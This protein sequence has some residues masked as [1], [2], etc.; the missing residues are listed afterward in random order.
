MSWGAG[1]RNSGPRWPS[2]SEIQLS[3]QRSTHPPTP[4]S[5]C[6]PAAHLIPNPLWRHAYRCTRLIKGY[7][8]MGSLNLPT[9]WIPLETRCPPR[10]VRGVAERFYAHARGD[11]REI[12][13][14]CGRPRSSCTLRCARRRR[15]AA[16]VRATAGTMSAVRVTTHD[17]IEL[18]NNVSGSPND[19]EQARLQWRVCVGHWRMSTGSTR[20]CSGAAPCMKICN[21]L[22]VPPLPCHRRST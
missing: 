18:G 14:G 17:G 7:H 2:T 3:L 4:P 1:R 9:E 19:G 6:R 5:F 20:V 11:V 10:T 12:P 21:S 8:A 13:Y 16:D 15:P 22:C